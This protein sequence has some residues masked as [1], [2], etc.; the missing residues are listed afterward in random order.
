LIALYK[1]L[2]GGWEH[3]QAVPPIR[4]PE[5][6]IAAAARESNGIRPISTVPDLSQNHP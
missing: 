3:Y 5:P 1:A 6:A 2:G 4:V